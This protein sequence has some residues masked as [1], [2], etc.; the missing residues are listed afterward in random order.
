MGYNIYI[1]MY[2]IYF[3]YLFPSLFLNVSKTWREGRIHKKMAVNEKHFLLKNRFNKKHFL[4]KNFFSFPSL[5][6]NVSNLARRIHKKK[7]L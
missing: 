5:F 6:L 2:F 1:Y 3:Y 7:W 4:L